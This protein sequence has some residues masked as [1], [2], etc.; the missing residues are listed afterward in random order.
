[1]FIVVYV[2]GSWRR[3]LMIESV[4]KMPHQQH[5]VVNSGCSGCASLA[6]EFIAL[7]R[8]VEMIQRQLRA[9]ANLQALL[10]AKDRELAA[11]RARLDQYEGSTTTWCDSD[12]EE[13]GEA[14]ARVQEHQL[15]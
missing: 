2:Q 10:A 9:T 4:T 13:D 11:C 1:M 15:S 12:V 14:T 8:R 3:V 7:Q 5:R 6:S